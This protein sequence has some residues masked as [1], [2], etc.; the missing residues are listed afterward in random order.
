MVTRIYPKVVLTLHLHELLVTQ[1]TLNNAQYHALKE[2]KKVT[3]WMKWATLAIAAAALI[4][5]A[6]ALFKSP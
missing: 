1:I 4:Q 5:I 3:F 2:Q 6:I